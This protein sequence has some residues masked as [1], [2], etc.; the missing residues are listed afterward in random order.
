MAKDELQDAHDEMRKEYEQFRKEYGK[1][2][3]AVQ[4]VSD[5]DVQDDIHGLLKRLEEVVE[6]VRTG[7]L[8]GSGAK[9]HREAREKFLKLAG[10]TD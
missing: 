7:G 9:G 1:I 10:G 2:L 5:A 8:M 3:E 6:E 4:R